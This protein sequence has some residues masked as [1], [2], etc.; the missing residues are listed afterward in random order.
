MGL[1]CISTGCRT[2]KNLIIPTGQQTLSDSQIKK[3]LT[4]SLDLNFFSA[5]AKVKLKTENESIKGK[6]WLRCKPDSVIWAVVKK[7]SIEGGRIQM[8]ADSTS[9]IYRLDKAYQ[10][11]SNS[12]LGEDLGI[13]TD[14]STL[15]HLL[16]GHN[17]PCDTLALWEAELDTSIWKIKS[18]FADFLI[19]LRVDAYTGHI[20]EGLIV[21]NFK[22][23]GQFFYNDYR[24]VIKDVWLPYQRTYTFSHPENGETKIDLS[25]SEIKLNEPKAIKFQIPSH[26]QRIK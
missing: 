9:V 23:E 13:T 8:T 25:F 22:G 19:D 20:L 15:S 14:L 6:M 2:K 17:I 26:Y 16:I 7:A 3:Q 11:V 21:S 5:T 1:A 4:Q 10:T 18:S 12:T 24:E